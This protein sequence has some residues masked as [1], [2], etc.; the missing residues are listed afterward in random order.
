MSIATN[1]HT[2]STTLNLRSI[3]IIHWAIVRD[4][5]RSRAV[6]FQN[7]DAIINMM[8][9][10]IATYCEAEHVFYQQGMHEV[11]K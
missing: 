3:I 4:A 8:I 6:S 5:V 11:L 2:K 10:V 1:T 7:K 9:D